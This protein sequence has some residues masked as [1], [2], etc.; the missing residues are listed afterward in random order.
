MLDQ[1]KRWIFFYDIRIE[2]SS[3]IGPSIPMPYIMDNLLVR[4]NDGDA[5]KLINNETAAI[6]IND[7]KIDKKNKIAFLLIQYSDKSVADPAFGNLI[8]GELRVEPKLEGEGIA[9]SAHLAISL[10]PI[11]QRGNVYLSLIEE[12]TGISRSKITPFFNS[13][14]RHSCRFKFTDPNGKKRSCRPL[15]KM[16]GHPSQSLI[17]DLKRGELRHIELINLMHKEDAFDEEGYTKEIHRSIKLKVNKN[18]DGN[19]AQRLLQKIRL[20]AKNDG[21]HE[22]RVTYHRWEGKDRTVPFSTIKDDIKEKLFTRVELCRVRKPI[23]QCSP[24]LRK[25]IMDF[26]IENLSILRN[27]ENKKRQ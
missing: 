18:C 5:V 16:Y 8:T 2:P 3:D 1:L 26:M 27:I 6:R 13:E 15:A 4:Q 19:T 23:P 17:D 10:D 20:L 24:K 25:D 14:F 7:M 12:V 21:Y 11:E 22:M 9:V